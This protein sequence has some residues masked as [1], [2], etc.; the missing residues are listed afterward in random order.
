MSN[1]TI[2]QI[3]AWVMI[4]FLLSPLAVLVWFCWSTDREME[5]DQSRRYEEWLRRPG[6]RWYR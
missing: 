2:F 6:R 5:R 3:A 4:A 1:M